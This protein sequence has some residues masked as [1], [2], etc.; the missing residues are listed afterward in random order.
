MRMAR[1]LWDTLIEKPRRLAADAPHT[2]QAVS[3]TA[4]LLER[5]SRQ[6][7]NRLKAPQ[8]RRR[9]LIEDTILRPGARR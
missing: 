2:E 1:W 7:A 6:V 9:H 4:E 3:E 5:R 8:P